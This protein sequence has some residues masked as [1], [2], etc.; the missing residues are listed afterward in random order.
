M[1]TA[2][3]RRNPL[4][5]LSEFR[6]VL[7]PIFS[8]VEAQ[9]GVSQRWAPAIDVVRRSGEIA[10]RA[11][12]PGLKAEDIKIEIEDDTVTLSGHVEEKLTKKEGRFLRRERRFGTFSRTIALPPEVDPASIDATCHDGVLELTIPM[13]EA[14]S[15]PKKVEIQARPA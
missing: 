7:N 14:N 5:D 1:T 4:F 3:N 10:I 13:P 6:G 12:V 2:L 8:D 11:D 15:N 9:L